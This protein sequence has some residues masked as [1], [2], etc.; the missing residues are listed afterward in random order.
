MGKHLQSLKKRYTL[1]TPVLQ[2]GKTGTELHM[3]D[4]LFYWDLRGQ[5]MTDPAHENCEGCCG[6][7]R[8]DVLREVACEKKRSF[9]LQ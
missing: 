5:L 3:Q 6:Q 1:H 9:F 4:R 8:A 2:E 7:R